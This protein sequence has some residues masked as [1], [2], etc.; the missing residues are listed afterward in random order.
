MDF[1]L[2][3][4]PNVP[5]F[6]YGVITSIVA[7]LLLWFV[8]SN[9]TKRKEQN[10]FLSVMGIKNSDKTF[11]VIPKRVVLDGCD[12]KMDIRRAHVTFE[13]M[14][15]ASYAERS[16]TLAGLQDKN[17]KVRSSKEFLDENRDDKANV[18]VICSPKANVV[19]REIFAYIS[20]EKKFD[21]GFNKSAKN[22]ERWEIKFDGATL[23]HRRVMTKS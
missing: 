5:D 10:P 14:L 17:I 20:E 4:L 2:D 23:S 8:R 22:P 13:D 19:A 12:E 3:K 9:V 16:L 21:I 11:I 15:A 7:G 6:I 1:I 18:I